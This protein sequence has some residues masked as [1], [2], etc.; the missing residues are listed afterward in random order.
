VGA[1][2]KI[3]D[4]ALELI[5]HAEPKSR[6]DIPVTFTGLRAGD[7]MAEEFL[8]RDESTEPTVDPRLLRVKSREIPAESFA[9]QMEDLS[10]SVDERNLTAMIET[11]CQ[12]VPDYRPTELLSPSSLGSSV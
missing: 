3:L 1:P 11:L 8:S 7:K 12:I 6:L 2:V 5:S 10:R 9:T 4:I